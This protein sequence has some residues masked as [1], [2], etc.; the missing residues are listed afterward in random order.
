M[1]NTPFSGAPI[2]NAAVHRMCAWHV[3]A[4]AAA[5]FCIKSSALR[6]RQRSR[7]TRY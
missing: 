3:P 4:Y 6:S 2:L 7:K 5:Q 1:R